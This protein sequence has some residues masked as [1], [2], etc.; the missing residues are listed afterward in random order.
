MK[1]SLLVLS[2]FLITGCVENIDKKKEPIKPIKENSST[3][4][5]TKKQLELKK[6]LDKYLEYLHSLNTEGIIDMTYPKLFIPIN[7]TIFKRYI[8][9]LLTSPHISVKSFDT[10]ITNITKVQSYSEGEFAQ[11][12][13]KATIKLEFINPNLYNDDLSIRVLKDTLQKKYGK[14]NIDINPKNRTIIIHEEQKLL[15]IKEKD[16]E[17]KFIGDNSEY[18]RLYPDIL[19]LDIISKI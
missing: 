5:Y 17:W 6:Y 13:Y 7:K 2:L 19:P 14:D 15:A 3:K 11:I 4:E 10:N 1:K 12:K 18:R 8:N 9:T 16:K